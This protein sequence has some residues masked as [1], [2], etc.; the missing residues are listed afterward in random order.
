MKTL[1][2][3][4]RRWLNWPPL[5][6][7]PAR[8]R[9]IHERRQAPR[10]PCQL[11]VEYRAVTAPFVAAGKCEL[12]DVSASG[13]A[14]LSPAPHDCGTMLEIKLSNPRRQFSC[15]RLWLIA[16]SRPA[17]SRQWIVG[18]PFYTELSVDELE[19]LCGSPSS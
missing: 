19:A 14:M 10:F 6:P 3:S 4:W 5:R 2:W 1:V 11:D 9:Q 13:A 17:A 7:L 18:G 15:K 8:H 12:R 16:H